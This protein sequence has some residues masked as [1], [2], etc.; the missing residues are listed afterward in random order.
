MNKPTLAKLA[1]P[2]DV[3]FRLAAAL[4]CAIC[5]L[6]VAAQEEDAAPAAPAEGMNPPHWSLEIRA[7]HFEPDLKEWETFYGDSKADVLG[8]SL[9]WK[10]LRQVEV[11]LTVDDIEDTGV[12]KLPLNGTLGGQVNF[13][14]YP[15][16]L[17][18]LLRG[19]FFEN[20]WVVPYVGGGISRVYYHEEIDNQGS[21]RGHTDGDHTRYGLQFLLDSI[22]KG[23]AAGFEEEG[24]ENTYLFV[25]KLS[26]SADLEGVELGGESTMFGLLFEF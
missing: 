5:A 16:Q 24:V 8:L 18:V 13:H 2:A 9:G 23:N 12:G 6:P 4:L 22:D 3:G 11:G 26:F 19:V 10:L 15:A 17:Y 21:V 1:F 14:M 25:E 20:Q 7:G